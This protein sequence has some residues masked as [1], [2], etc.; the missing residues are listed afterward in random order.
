MP[1]SRLAWAAALVCGVVQVMVQGAPTA[2]CI[3]WKAA[4]AYGAGRLAGHGAW[5]HK[6]GGG[7][8]PEGVAQRVVSGCGRR[9]VGG[10]A[11]DCVGGAA[12]GY[13]A[14]CGKQPGWGE[15][16]LAAAVLH[17]AQPWGVVQL[18]GGMA[19]GEGVGRGCAPP[20]GRMLQ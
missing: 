8:W 6:V 19:H 1:T 18:A 10:V 7:A 5:Q 2:A 20:H 13:R 9:R 12:H 14:W 17:G 4:L 15:H 3:V 11:C 16:P